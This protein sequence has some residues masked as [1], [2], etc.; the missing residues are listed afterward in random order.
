M[1]IRFVIY[2]KRALAKRNAQAGA[3]RL[4]EASAAS[5]CKIPR[6]LG[7]RM[8]SR[9]R[10]GRSED[11]GLRPWNRT[12]NCARRGQGTQVGCWW[13]CITSRDRAD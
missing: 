2:N 8:G 1:D 9:S 11:V 7:R 5:G 3:N 4:A 12:D 13:S 6:K 10:S